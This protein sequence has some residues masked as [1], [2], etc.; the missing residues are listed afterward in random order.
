ML[1]LNKF[2]FYAGMMISLIGTLIGIPVLIFGSQKVGIY[3]VTICVPFGFLLWFTGFVAYTFLRPND[4][5]RKDDQAHSEAEQ[6]QR[7]VP[8]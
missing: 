4:M 7:R 2:M 5:R 6:Y 1:A 3:L 8:D